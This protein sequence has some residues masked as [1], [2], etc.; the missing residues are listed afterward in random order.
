[1]STTNRNT[2]TLHSPGSPDNLDSLLRGFFQAEMPHPWPTMKAPVEKR[3]PRAKAEP[4]HWTPV[5]SRLALAAS[6]GLL[7][8]GS[9]YLSAKLPEYAGVNGETIN[10]GSGNADRRI[11]NV[12]GTGPKSHRVPSK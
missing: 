6:V 10:G 1:M 8:V 4:K 12:E 9:W 2:R 5:R 7:M 11:P 3:A